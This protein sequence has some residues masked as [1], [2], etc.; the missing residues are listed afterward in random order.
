[1]NISFQD[2]KVAAN[3]VR[4]HYVGAGTGDPVV[5]ISGWPQSWYAWRRVMPLLADAGYRTIAFDPPGLGDSDLL[6]DGY[7]TGRVAEV[8][9]NALQTLGLKRVDLVGH[10]VGTW[11]S[12]AYATRYP[13]AVRRL[14]LLEAALPGVTPEAAFGLANASKVFQFYLNAVAELPEL[15]TRGKEREFLAWLFR[16]K[17]ANPEAIGSADLDEYARTYKNSARMTAGFGYYRAVQTDIEQ[18]KAAGRLVMP[19]LALGGEKSVGTALYEALKGHADH[20]E[21]GQI[22]RYG[23]YLPEECPNELARRILSFFR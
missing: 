17:S 12:Y 11:I 5:L 13:D 14:V 15:L 7:D 9:Q 10:D 18:N 23:H 19:T 21:G 20:L 3:G 2:A 6:P 22:D 1:M 8:L 16:T 4:L